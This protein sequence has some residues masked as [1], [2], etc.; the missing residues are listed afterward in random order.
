MSLSYSSSNEKQSCLLNILCKQ[1][2][3]F[4][5]VHFNARSLNGLKL[6]QVKYVFEN[7]AVDVICVS[8]T[9]FSNDVSCDFYKIKGYDLF[10]NNRVHKRG[11]GVAI[12][13][14][15]SLKS[16]IVSKSDE[17][18]IEYLNV[19]IYDSLL[20]LFISSDTKRVLLFDQISF[21]SDHDLIFCSFDVYFEKNDES[22][23]ILYRDF[24]SIDMNGLV[25]DL[26][27]GNYS[28]CWYEPTVDGKLI[29][30]MT[31][32]HEL[33]DK[34]VPI[35]SLRIQNTSCP[36]FTASIQH[37]I[38]E[39]NKLHNAWKK[40][41]TPHNWGVYTSARNHTNHIIIK[42]KQVY[43]GCN[44]STSLPPKKTL[45]KH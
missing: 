13:V 3:G 14:K 33:Y 21:L 39:R 32:L 15:S 43:F 12:Y 42:A 44:L 11:G 27:S 38:R 29:A 45:E 22:K 5:V 1:H 25:C 26:L 18:E 6:D 16:N 23:T 36:W 8:E 24:K 4:N 34:H 9:W 31:V 17:T 20:D 40:N 10:S 28:S 35:R 41:S 19:E 7:S 37:N 2:K 30:L